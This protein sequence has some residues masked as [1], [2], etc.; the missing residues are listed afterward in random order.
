[1]R[2]LLASA[3]LLLVA[4]GTLSV[5]EERR[6]GAEMQ[7]EIQN[8]VIFLRDRVV[9]DYVA[10]IGQE[11][12]RASGPQPFEYH[13]QVVEDEE[14]NAFAAPAGYVYV[15]TGTLLK[16]RNVSELA[17]VIGHEVGHVARRHIAQNYN[18]M[19]NTG[20]ARQAAVIAAGVTGGNL[21]AGAANLL[22]GLA[23]LAYVNSFT[24][25]AEADADAFAVEVLP[26]AGYDPRGLVSF[27]HTLER[28]GGGG[29]PPGFLSSHPAPA[30]RIEATSRL[31]AESR[32]P[33]GLR[34]EDGGRFEIIQR[35]IQILTG[36]R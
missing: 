32:L 31:I 3:L 4:C 11:I 29:A 35:R 15:N 26:R 7:R 2:W 19:R 10:G 36:A 6:L 34:V 9:N 22:G 17:G 16:A 25:E 5:P 33:S 27:F 30:S 23:G 20:I 28:E 14:I 18:R 21:G 24:R 13:F 12:V 1:M 8:E